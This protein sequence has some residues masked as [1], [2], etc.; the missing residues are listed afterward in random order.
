MFY[1]VE[2]PIKF[3]TKL[4]N[5]LKINFFYKNTTF[6]PNNYRKYIQLNSRNSNSYNLKDH[7]TR[8]N[9]TVS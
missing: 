8:T 5:K 4:A 2:K 9:S 7:L 3:Y 6:L 1:M